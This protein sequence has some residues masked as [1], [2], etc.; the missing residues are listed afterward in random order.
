MLISLCMP[1]DPGVVVYLGDFDGDKKTDRAFV[2]TDDARW[3]LVLTNSGPDSKSWGSQLPG[4]PAFGVH[5]GDF[6]GDGKADRLYISD[7]NGKWHII[8]ATGQLGVPGISW[9]EAMPPGW[10]KSGIV[11]ADFNGDR[12]TDR[13]FVS[14]ID[15]KWYV[16]LTQNGKDAFPLGAP[17]IPWGSEAA[18]GWSNEVGVADFNG[19]GIAD[20]AFLAPGTAKWHIVDTPTRGIIGTWGEQLP[21]W[22]DKGVQVA[23]VDG[24]KKS[25]RIYITSD[26][27]VHIKR[28]TGELGSSL[29]A[30]GAPLPPGWDPKRVVFTDFDGDGKDDPSFVSSEGKWHVVGSLNGQPG[31]PGISWGSNP[32]ADAAPAL[33]DSFPSSRRLTGLESWKD[34]A[35]ATVVDTNSTLA[36]HKAGWTTSCSKCVRDVGIGAVVGGTGGVAGGLL[37][38]LGAGFCSDNCERCISDRQTSEKG[39]PPERIEHPKPEVFGPP[40]PNER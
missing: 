7:V 35:R 28:A 23:D 27:H 10:L 3:Y 14:P 32:F 25:D 38:G 2:S 19:D 18:P 17:G 1:S 34:M 21:G 15:S 13:A 30:W 8:T 12:K 36:V 37:G 16:L 11:L 6:D 20:R 31:V 26:G 39:S 40:D 9:G 29:F 24:D 4:W 33:R 5:I 22:P